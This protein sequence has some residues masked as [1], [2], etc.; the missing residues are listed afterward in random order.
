M[1]GSSPKTSSEFRFYPLNI[2][3]GLV[4]KQTPM[5]WKWELEHKAQPWAYSRGATECWQWSRARIEQLDKLYIK[6]WP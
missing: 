3:R 6:L 4:A 5:E 1:F 2:I